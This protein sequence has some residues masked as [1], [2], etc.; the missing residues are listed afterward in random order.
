MDKYS[1]QILNKLVEKYEASKSFTGQNLVTQNFYL[2]IAGE[3]PKYKDDS[4]FDTFSDINEAVTDLKARQWIEFQ[5]GRNGIVKRVSLNLQYLQ[6]IYSALGKTSKVEDNQWLK[7]ILEGYAKSTSILMEY[8]SKQLA[9]IYANKKVEFYSGNHQN[10]QDVLKICE[11]IAKNKTEIYI[12]DLSIRVFGDSKRLE[13]IQGKVESLLYQCGNYEEKKSVFEECGVVK[14]P[15][16]VT[17]KGKGRLLFPYQDIDLS[18]IDGDIAISS[19][20]IESLLE[21]QILGM[22]VITIENLTTFHDYANTEDFCIYLGGFHNQIKE[23]F[24]KKMYQQNQGKEFYHF[25]DIDAGGFYIYEH[26][27]HKTMIPFRLMNMNVAIL[28]RYKDSWKKLTDNDKKRLVKL[29]EKQKEKMTQGVEE[30]GDYSG[31]LEYML[32]RN[33]KLEQ[34]AVEREYL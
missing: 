27:L 14:T 19:K 24:I 21:I 34:E 33:C 16:Y 1:R 15:T 5:E 25:G 2:H 7:T 23:Q 17:M 9:N 31:V 10:Y 13:Q 8:A 30:I 26:L 3:F 12:R 18:K 6:E 22:R 32:E 4:D 11:F 28:E 29:L 20:T